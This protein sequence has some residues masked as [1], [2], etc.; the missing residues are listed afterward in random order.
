MPHYQFSHHNGK[1][2]RAGIN[3]LPGN[4]GQK[5]AQHGYLGYYIFKQ[6]DR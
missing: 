4:N 6:I 2:L 1:G 3:T 5:N